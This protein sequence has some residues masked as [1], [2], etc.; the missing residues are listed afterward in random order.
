MLRVVR[1][2]I[3]ERYLESRFTGLSGL[4]V[5]STVALFPSF[6]LLLFLLRIVQD[7]ELVT[8]TEKSLRFE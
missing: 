3:R 5:R 6:F 1:V 7:S 4:D 8:Y 2:V